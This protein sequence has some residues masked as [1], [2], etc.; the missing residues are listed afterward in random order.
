MLV[1]HGTVDREVPVDQAR[2]WKKLLPRHPIT[3]VEGKGRDHRFMVPGKCDVAELAGQISRW[4]R[5]AVLKP[6]R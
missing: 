3:V 1:L 2:G 5:G 6:S 4:A